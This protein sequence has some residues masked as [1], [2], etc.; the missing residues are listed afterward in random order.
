M[1]VR[2]W[3]GG[4]IY[5]QRGLF[6]SFGTFFAYGLKTLACWVNDSFLDQ[7]SCR[8]RLHSLNRI[9]QCVLIMVTSIVLIPF[10]YGV[11]PFKSLDQ[12]RNYDSIV[13]QLSTE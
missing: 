13:T 10:S 6:G 1:F 12:K 11:L 8:V 7:I 3:G 4:G 9:H 5:Y 2:G